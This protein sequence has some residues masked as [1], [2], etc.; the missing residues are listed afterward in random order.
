VFTE[1]EIAEAASKATQPNLANARWIRMHVANLMGEQDMGVGFISGDFTVSPL[2]VLTP[3]GCGYYRCILP[4]LVCGQ[5]AHAGRVAW[6]PIRG[7]GIRDTNTTGVFGFSTIV[8]KL[9]MDRWIPRQI[10]LAQK[11]GQKIIVDIDDYFEGLTPANKAYI[12]THPESNKRTNRD[13]YQE[14]I[15][16]ADAVTVSTPFLLDH[17]EKQRNNVHMVRNGVNPN[18]FPK[19][20]HSKRKPV[21]G[22]TGA[23][24]YRNND[25]EQLQAWLPQFLERH[26]L[27][28]HH[29][30]HSN[31]APAFAEVTGV[32]PH[33]VTTT[34]LVPINDYPSGFQFD[35]GIVPLNDIPFNYAKSNIK[36]LEYAAANIPFVASDV[37]EYRLLHEDGVGHIA[38]TP[39][40]WVNQMEH[41]LVFQTRKQEADRA[42]KTVV[43][44]WSIQAR[45]KDWQAVF[46]AYGKTPQPQ[47]TL[48]R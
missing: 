4:M 26:D 9:M 13:Y 41:L 23:T 43:D 35:I 29:A 38:R 12:D 45:A 19:V 25:L 14:V 16:K 40:E 8:L 46:N 2:G 10:E 21:L 31:N 37:P 17:Y 27:M 3:G 39:E 47:E 6:D 30:G 18:Q 44:N 36:G 22:W 11:L 20:T 42:H 1:Q 28:I 33:R 34:P 5:K 24:S 32:Q 15:A 7:F 48:G